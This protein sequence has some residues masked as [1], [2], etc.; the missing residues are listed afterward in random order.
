MYLHQSQSLCIQFRHKITIIG[1]DETEAGDR[2]IPQDTP[3]QPTFLDYIN[4]TCE[5]D[6]SV[7]IDFTASNGNPMT[8]GTPHYIDKDSLNE[9][10]KAMYTIGSIVQK[11]DSEK[12]SQVWGFE[13]KYDNVV[14]NAFQVGDESHLWGVKGILEGYRNTFK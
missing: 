10:E 7:A 3:E 5:L 12:L 6:L 9:Y 1:D 4:G 13:A 11:Y 14:R 8:P 2:S